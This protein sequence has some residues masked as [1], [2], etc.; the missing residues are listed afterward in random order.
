MITRGM[1]AVAAVTLAVLTG[2]PA[3]P[4]GAAAL[5]HPRAEEWWFVSW[6]VEKMA[7]P[8]STG[9]GITVAV[10][11][12][13]VNANLPELRGVV[14]PGTDVSGQYPGDGRQDTDTAPEQ[15]G[16]DAGHGTAMAALIAGQGG[17]AGMVGVA[18]GAKIMPIIDTGSSEQD[19]KAI[20]YAA[21]H[22]AQVISISQAAV[23]FGNR[24]DANV[25]QAIAYATTQ[26][27]VVVVAG[28]GNDGDKNNPVMFPAA[29]AGVLA[30]G[31]VDAK[32]K[33]WVSTE[34]QSY[35]MVSAPGYL[36]GSI[37]KH[38]RY[39]NDISGTSQATAL[40]SAAVA[41][42][43]AKYPDLSARDVVQRIINTTHHMGGGGHDDQ[44]GY[45]V[46]LPPAAL[47]RNV[48]KSAPNP[49]FERLDA[50][51]AAHPQASAGAGRPGGSPATAGKST[52]QT[53]LI[54]VL[55]LVVVVA[56][57][58]VVGL[59]RVSRRRAR[60]AVP[61]WQPP[62]QGGLP[63]SFGPPRTGPQPPPGQRPT[64]FPPPQ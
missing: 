27:N 39:M 16:H 64:Y 50:W 59:V 60:A 17:G 46:V 9:Q 20:R 1:A 49:P 51:L 37:D 54:G 36:V 28:A 55:A 43:R 13:G 15:A 23:A 56:G 5:P 57:V 47:T 12:T 45:G 14:V 44:T 61:Q 3:G 62:Q 25:Q 32:P 2:L 4:A 30:V 31:A 41:L 63:P 52:S 8:E 22:G 19:S 42:V 58:A 33:A 6:G 18:P 26:K 53:G 34:R 11:D 35:V 21:D 40:T 29:C 10:I 38:G 7:W 24:C 48:D